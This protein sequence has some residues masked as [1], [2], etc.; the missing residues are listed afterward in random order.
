MRH[1][2]F[3]SHLILAIFGF[4]C[5]AVWYAGVPAFAVTD[6]KPN[7]III[8]VDD[9][10]WADLSCFGNQAIQTPNID[11]LA[12]EGTAFTQFYVSAP[13]CSPSRCALTTGQYPYRWRITSFLNN[14]ADNEARGMAQWLD[15]LAPVLGRFFHD[16]GYATGHFGKWHLGG[17]RDV[18]EAPLIT[19]YGF[20]DSLTNFEGLGPRVLPLLNAFDGTEP[21]KHALGSDTLGRGE[22]RWENRN[23]VTTRFVE[24]TLE[25]IQKAEKDNKPF[26][27]NLWPDDVHSPFFPSAEL[28]G[29]GSKKQLYHGVLV[30]LDRQLAPLFDYIRGNEKLR[31]NTLIVLLGDNGPEPGAGS[32]DPLRGTKGMLYEGGT[33]SSLVVWGQGLMENDAKGTTNAEAVFQSVDL[34]P[35]ILQIAGIRTDTAFDGEDFS[36]VI[37]GKKKAQARNA[38]IF[39]RRPPDRPGPFNEPWPDLALRDGDWKFLMRF[40]GSSPELYDL[41]NDVA[42]S[43]NLAA[44]HPALVEKYTEQ[45]NRWNATMPK[46]AGESSSTPGLKFEWRPRRNAAPCDRS[47]HGNAMEING[48]IPPKRDVRGPFAAFDGKSFIHVPNAP[49]LNF[50]GTPLRVEVVCEPDC[51]NAVILARGGT[52]QGFALFLKDGKPGCATRI[53]GEVYSAISE[54]AVTG[55]MTIQAIL[56]SGVLELY[57]NAKLAATKAVPSFLPNNPHDAMQIGHDSDGQVLHEE[58][59]LFRGKIRRVSLWR[60]K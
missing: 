3:P 26:F 31:D 33:R 29:D 18:G 41:A 2:H 13:I 21:A 17:Q 34:V 35:S 20:D 53:A 44:Q 30:E 25:F 59:P 42:E 48:D 51:E 50:G 11:R 16:A 40:D 37:L 19:E 46:D 8:L 57:V 22:I 55:P 39:W 28:R 52:E 4:L 38:P 24:K 49:A 47:G 27:I 7:V 60:E 58:M 14:R 6:S 15:L 45:L 43:L 56:K 5:Y 12:A 10:G 9:M 32:A 23:K 54:R 36:E 1:L